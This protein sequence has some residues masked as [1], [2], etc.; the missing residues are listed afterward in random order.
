VPHDV[1]QRLTDDP[2]HVAGTVI[3]E[4]RLRA[5]ISQHELAR[6]A[7]TSQAT[8]SAYESGSKQ[9]SIPTLVRIL[10]AAGFEPRIRLSPVRHPAGEITRS[11]PSTKSPGLPPTGSPLPVVMHGS[12]RN[13]PIVTPAKPWESAIRP[14]ARAV[15]LPVTLDWS[16]AGR[17]RDLAD[18]AERASVYGKILREGTPE[19]VVHW[20]D[21]DALVDV[22][23]DLGLPR[24]VARAWETML[25]RWGRW[26]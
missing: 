1:D 6:R 17:R 18:P 19:D 5:D 4:A 10:E 14:D 9:P 16:P 20:V 7:R 23:H 12:F 25:R 2:Q 3:R 8:L 24:P 11:K 21:L 15:I 13:R 22:W 26:R